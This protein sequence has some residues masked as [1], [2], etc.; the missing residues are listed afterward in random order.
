M[1]LRKNVPLDHFA[2][3]DFEVK[4]PISHD[5]GCFL[6]INLAQKFVYAERT[7]T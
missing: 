7:R 5:L 6:T 3:L 1:D 4:E 2:K